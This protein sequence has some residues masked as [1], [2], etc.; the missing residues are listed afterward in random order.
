MKNLLLSAISLKTNGTNDLGF[1]SV[2]LDAGVTII[3][4]TV[5]G[6]IAATAVFF[7]IKGGI[8]YTVSG[9]DPAGVKQAKETIMYAI[10]GLIVALLAFGAVNFITGKA[11]TLN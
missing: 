1:P 5:F 4:N 3:L 11:G 2:S 9:G 8:K 6:A 10:I 7:I